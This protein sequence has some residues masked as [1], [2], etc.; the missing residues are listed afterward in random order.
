MKKIPELELIVEEEINMREDFCR[1]V[2]RLN[3]TV[4]DKSDE[5]KILN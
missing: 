1:E 3:K 5:Y 4:K 2:D